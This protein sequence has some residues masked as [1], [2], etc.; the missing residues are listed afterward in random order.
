MQRNLLLG[1]LFIFVVIAITSIFLSLQTQKNYVTHE[2]SITT[3][4]F[5]KI[6][7]TPV[8]FN[9]T[10]VFLKNGSFILINNVTRVE[11]SL[12]TTQAK[13]GD[14]VELNVTYIGHFGWGG[15]AFLQNLTEWYIKRMINIH[16]FGVEFSN[17]TSHLLVQNNGPWDKMINQI[18]EQQQVLYLS[19]T[20]YF[21]IR[22]IITPTKNVVGK[23]LKICGGY[24]AT[25]KNITKW[26]D[27]YN[28][29]A[30]QQAFVINSSIISI[31]SVNCELLKVVEG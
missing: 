15:D 26:A 28:K 11:V 23:T 17:E 2:A 9:L 22:W 19:P 5:Q 4:I 12:N 10:G 31:P 14:K 24:F 30:Y 16:Y 20:N 21:R 3:S 27:Y 8:S 7:A 29:L 18:S 13:P 6:N 1:F 25:Y